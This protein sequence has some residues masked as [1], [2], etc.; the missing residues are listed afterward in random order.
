MKKEIV[1]SLLAIVVLKA[2][3]LF[4]HHI[5]EDAF[6]TWRVAQN[7]LD[8]GV[9]GF[10]GDIKISASTT[11]LYTFVSYLFNLVFGKEYF[12]YPLLIFNSTLF[13]MG[14]WYLVRIFF[15]NTT[16]IILGLFFLNF[17]PPSIKI[18]ILGMEYGLIFYLYTA[19]LYFGMMRRKRWAYWIFPILLLWARLDSAIFLGLFFLFD[20][21]KYRRWNFSLMWAGMVGLGSVLLF[22]FFYFGDWINNTIIA[23]NIAYPYAFRW[24]VF[25]HYFPQYTG[26]IKIPE[27]LISVN[28]LTFV[29]LILE[30]FAFIY[31]V[32]QSMIPH[33]MILSFLFVFAWIKQLIFMGRLSL[34]DWYYWTPQIFLFFILI[35][36]L[37]QL[38]KYKSWAYNFGLLVMIPMILYQT[39]HSVA[40][41]N[42]EWN[43]R[44]NIG[45]YLNEYEQDKDQTIFLEPAGY[46]PYFSQL[47]TIDFVGLVDKGVQKHLEADNQYFIQPTLQERKPKYYLSLNPKETF[48]SKADSLYFHDN[49]LKI[50]HFKIKPFL[51]SEHELLKNIFELKPS[52][53]DYWLYRRYDSF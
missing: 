46:I 11:H 34:F 2:L 18:S 21:M 27:N 28:Y 48:R 5:Q 14:T 7:L 50:K 19:M 53:R 4:T 51:D 6:I 16:K 49:Y 35:I 13:T 32:M 8:Y 24:K 29:V 43:Y 10:N 47:K 45:L 39:A 22:N 23:K 30:L 33:K 25:A 1:F 9:I 42:A 31:L 3:F 41:G 37:L 20:G 38:P 36:F 12:M 40:S 26:L 15:S 52:G 44:R 17:L